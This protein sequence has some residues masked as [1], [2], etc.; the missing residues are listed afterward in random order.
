[1]TRKFV[2]AFVFTL[3][4][5]LLGTTLSAQT[6]EE[7]VSK[8]IAARGG[9]DKIRAVKSERVTGTVSIGPETDGKLLVERKRP[10]KMYTEVTIGGQSLIRVYDGK[11]AGWTYN[12]FIPNPTVQPMSQAELSNI[13]DES[14]FDGP[15]VDY[16]SKGNQLDFVDK[17][18][19]LGK[20]A[21][22]IK[23]TSKKGE[24][25]QFYFD[26]VTS[27][28]L[29][30]E[31]DRKVGDKSVPWESFFHDFREVN[32]LK[33]PFLIESD[34]PGTDQRQ[35]ITADNIEVNIPIP[36]ARFEKPNP[37]ATPAAKT[38]SQ[39]PNQN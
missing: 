10:G 8:Y 39:P 37:P 5:A 4:F 34:A 16:K 21:Y 24:V 23:L 17:E 12:P 2:F 7:I 30:W 1:M 29:K 15:F 32:G 6:A 25:T 14:D 31:G 35:K 18:E 20:T 33:Y 22:K 27:L 19:V 36:D 3:A 38:P 26:A 28:L 9:I 11:S 13:T